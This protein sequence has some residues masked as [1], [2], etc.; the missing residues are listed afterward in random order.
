MSKSNLKNSTKQLKTQQIAQQTSGH[1]SQNYEELKQMLATLR[2]EIASLR[3]EASELA[4]EGQANEAKAVKQEAKSLEATV[5]SVLFDIAEQVPI[6]GNLVRW[7][8]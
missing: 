4:A 7:F 1:E 8:R 2:K 3:K 6:L 5:G